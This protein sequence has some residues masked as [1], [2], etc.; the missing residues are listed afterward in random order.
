MAEGL[1][2]AADSALRPTEPLRFRHFPFV[3]G[4]AQ[5]SVPRPFFTN[6]MFGPTPLRDTAL[7]AGFE[8]REMLRSRKA[9]G[10][11]L[12]YLLAASFLAYLFVDLL[13]TVQDAAKN[14]AAYIANTRTRPEQPGP[15]RPPGARRGGP[16]FAPSPSDKPSQGILTSRGSVF[17]ALVF[18]RFADAETR[19]SLEKRPPIV[20]YFV[21]TSFFFVPL[22]I[23]ITSA[24]TVAQEHQSRGVRFVAMRT[25]RAEFALG[26]ALGQGALLALVTLLAGVACLGIA[27]WKLS[28]FE[29]GPGLEGLLVFWPRVLAYSLPFLGLAVFCSMNAASAMSARVFALL[30]LFALW[31]A[32]HA[33]GLY[34]GSTFESFFTALDFL[35]PYPHQDDLWRPVWSAVGPQML[36]LAGLA[37]GYVCVGLVFYRRRDL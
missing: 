14:P 37:L 33:A 12:L 5:F 21:L 35:T 8:L 31:L 36:I 20:L 28:D 27:A 18:N 9:L 11:I 25:G 22:L 7:V 34:A 29:W 2:A 17:N 15:G 24:E 13:Q 26:K 19:E 10:V 1:A 23:M 4:A 30:G 16:V 3:W 32:H 6:L